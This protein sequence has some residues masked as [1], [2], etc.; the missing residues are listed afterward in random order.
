[1]KHVY[2]ES[3]VVY[4]AD[5]RLSRDMLARDLA[6]DEELVWAGRPKLGWY[7]NPTEAFPFGM[8]WMAFAL[9]W[10]VQVIRVG[11]GSFALFGLPFLSIGFYAVFSPLLDARK[12]L[13]TFYG[14][15]NRRVLIAVT[16][17]TRTLV[18]IN[19][20]SVTTVSL[21]EMSDGTGNI[22]F[23][24]PH[25][26]ALSGATNVPLPDPPSLCRVPSA[27]AVVEAIAAVHAALRFESSDEPECSDSSG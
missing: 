23:D 6:T 20:S 1:M 26:L 14:L 27:H 25:V 2:R 11:A 7:L 5:E 8:V 12:R 18:S 9:F 24:R 10:E 19:L 3:A 4:G 17:P 21:E 16:S 15:T 13:R 22:W